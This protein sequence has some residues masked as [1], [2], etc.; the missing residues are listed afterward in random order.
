[1][2][3]QLECSLSQDTFKHI[4]IKPILLSCGHSICLSCIP[5]NTDY[6]VKCG[7]CNCLNEYDLL[8]PKES[9]ATKHLFELNIKNLFELLYEKFKNALMEFKE[10]SGLF[11]FKLAK[12]VEF[13]REEIDIRIESLKAELDLLREQMFETLD[14]KC[15]KIIE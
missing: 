15:N 13:L 14:L 12:R 8:V 11:D 10:S 4:A 2:I 5:L 6:K 1:M 3:S 7:R 9:T